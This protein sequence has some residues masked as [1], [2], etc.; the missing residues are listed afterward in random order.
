MINLI[1]KVFLKVKNIISKPFFRKTLLQV[2]FK[3]LAVSMGIFTLKWFNNLDYLSR[4]LADEYSKQLAFNSIIIGIFSFGISSVIQKE[5]TNS[6]DQIRRAN[7]VKTF[8]ILRL[9]TY[10]ASII[11]IYLLYVLNLYDFGYISTLLPKGNIWFIIAVFSTQFVMFSDINFRSIADATARS[12][13]FSFTDLLSK[14]CYVSLL[15]ISISMLPQLSANSSM[16]AI[17]LSG[18]I[19]NTIFLVFDYWYYTKDLPKANFDIN[20]IKD[21]LSTMIYVG[22]IGLYTGIVSKLDV[23]LLKGEPGYVRSYSLAYQ[24]FETIMIIPNITMPVLATHIKRSVDLK[25]HWPKYLALI[26]LLGLGLSLT[27]LY[28]ANLLLWITLASVTYPLS[29]LIMP[30]FLLGFIPAFGISLLHNLMVFEGL[31]KIETYSL[32]CVGIVIISGYFYFIPIYGVYGAAYVTIAGMYLELII[33]L[34][35]YYRLKIRNN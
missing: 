20:L 9:G 2:G 32:I 16:I 5:F 13:V 18:I 17:A 8:N 10:V 1:Y 15:Y 21:N 31:E 11:L 34:I 22:L 28:G 23:I 26:L 6:F 29:S 30:I 25:P 12:W 33:K 19:G 3:I 7:V 24:I 35:N 27:G 14:V 4:D